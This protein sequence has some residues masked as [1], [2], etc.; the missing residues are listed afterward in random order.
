MK[1]RAVVTGADGGMG[2]EITRAVA[3][4]GYAVVMLCYTQEKGERTRKALMR[5]TGNE[6]IVVKQVDLS[7]V[8]S[9]LHVTNELLAEGEHIDLLMNNAGT[10]STH[11]ARTVDGVERTVAVNYLAPFLLTQRLLPLMGKG[12]RV[13]NM[14][15]CTYAIGKITPAFFTHGKE[16]AFWRIPVYSNTKLALWLFTHELARRWA[17]RGI[18]VNAAD[19]GV[20]STNIIRMDMWFDPLT[21]LF[22]RPF[23]RTP[24]QGAAT[25]VS[26][27]LDKQWEGIT[28][29]M[30]ASGKQKTPKEVFMHHPQAETLWTDTEK[31]LRS[32]CLEAPKN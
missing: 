30:F 9:V 16:G 7:S 8:V 3:R 32:L 26:L 24:K 10:L 2:T 1:K 4:A 15:S 25:A 19:P 23:I 22:F 18:T 14:I 6:Q 21:D 5:E 28:G 29:Q 11:F 17:D 13:V 27:L 31:L 12:T 20:V